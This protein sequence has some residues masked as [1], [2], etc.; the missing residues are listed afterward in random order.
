MLT[1]DFVTLSAEQMQNVWGSGENGNI[2]LSTKAPAYP[3]LKLHARVSKDIDFI[4]IHGWLFSGI[5]DLSQTYKY[6]VLGEKTDL[7][8]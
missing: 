6:S 8:Q 5:I 1:S 3:Q 2:I 4:Y 7:H